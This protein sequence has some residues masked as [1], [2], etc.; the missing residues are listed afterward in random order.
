MSSVFYRNSFYK[1]INLSE[2][3]LTMILSWYSI[4]YKKNETGFH[5]LFFF[6]SFLIISL[7]IS[8]K[9]DALLFSL[10]MFFLFIIMSPFLF[11]TGYSKSWKSF[12][13]SIIFVISS[14]SNFIWL[15]ISFSSYIYQLYTKNL[16]KILFLT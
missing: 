16:N 10:L 9:T 2:Q 3:P 11:I 7:K 4:E 13:I 12:E 5:T 14:F 15:F 6:T 1:V 8:V